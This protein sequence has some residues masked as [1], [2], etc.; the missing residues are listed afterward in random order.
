MKK[1]TILAL[2]F[3]LILSS[4]VFAGPKISVPEKDWDFGNIPQNS[5][6]RHAYWILNI[7]DDTL[8]ILSVKPG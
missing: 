4:I 1:M 8:R 5:I 3:L 7:G 6:A 2:I